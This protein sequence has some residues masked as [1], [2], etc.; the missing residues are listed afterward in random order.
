MSREETYIPQARP[1]KHRAMPVTVPF[2]VLFRRGLCL[3]LSAPSGAGKTAITA[4]L[5]A[6]EPD[7][8]V[9]VSATT[10]APRPGETHGV[11]Y[12]FVTEADF[13]RMDQQG[14]LL[15]WAR[16]LAGAH[17]YGTTR[18]P[19]EQALSE[20]LDVVFDIDW[21]GHQALRKALPGDVVSVFILPPTLSALESRL[22]GRAGDS[23]TEIARRMR[24]A[25]DEISHWREFDHVIVNGQLDQAVDEVAAILRAARLATPRQTGLEGFVAG[26]M[27]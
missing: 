19:V 9:S 2:P 8:R 18:A 24:Q 10:R 26:L 23:E 15:E 14:G 22:R 6:R 17:A 7:L 11:H 5:R 12:H 20:G 13:T 16:V 21:Q 1:D 27:A 4:G 25:R 3:V